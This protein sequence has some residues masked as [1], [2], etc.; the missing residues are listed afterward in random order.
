[1]SEVDT[2]WT[3]GGQTSTPP[4]SRYLIKKDGG[5]GNRT[6]YHRAIMASV[7]RRTTSGY[8]SEYMEYSIIYHKK[9]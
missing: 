4:I 5:H 8:I 2:V 7:I 1:M 9:I 3:W 6:Q